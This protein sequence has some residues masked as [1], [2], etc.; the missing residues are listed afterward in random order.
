MVSF[1]PHIGV[2]VQYEKVQQQVFIGGEMGRLFETYVGTKQGSEL[3]PL[4]IGMFTDMLHELMQMQVPGAGPLLEQLRVPDISYADDVTL[5]AYDDPAQLQRLLD[6]LSI[7][8]AIF[9][10]DVNEHT[11]RKFCCGLLG[12]EYKASILSGFEIWRHCC[13]I[14][15]LLQLPGSCVA[16]NKTHVCSC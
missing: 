6:C 5:I 11:L 15:G 14:Q 3:S 10:M 13:A 9:K 7:F 12:P 16:C 4:L 1:E 8:C 2:T